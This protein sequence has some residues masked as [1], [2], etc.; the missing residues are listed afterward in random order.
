MKNLTELE[1]ANFKMNTCC[2]VAPWKPL[3]IEDFKIYLPNFCETSSTTEPLTTIEVEKCSRECVE[4][5]ESLK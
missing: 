1:T 4:R 3:D 5:I 2:N